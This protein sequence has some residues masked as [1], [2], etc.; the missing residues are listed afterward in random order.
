MLRICLKRAYVSA[1]F[2]I[3]WAICVGAATI[4]PA[5]ALTSPANGVGGQSILEGLSWNTAASATSYEAQVST[6]SVFG[7]TFFDQIGGTGFTSALVANLSPFTTYYWRAQASDSA[8]SSG[9][10]A[11]RSFTTVHYIYDTATG[12]S[13][14]IA[15]PLSANPTLN[16]VPLN[17][18][19]EIGV[20][21]KAGLCVGSA[22]W[23][24]V[25]NQNIVVVGQDPESPTTDGLNAGDSMFFRVWDYSAGKEG[26]ATVTFSS[27]GATYTADG[28]SQIS[29]LTALAI[30]DQPTLSSPANGLG[31]QPTVLTLAWNTAAGAASYAIQVST[32]SVFS[33]TVLSQSG[34]TTLSRAVTG[35]SYQDTY[36]W[37]VNATNTLGTSPWSSVWS[38]S[39]APA[40]PPV[41]TLSAP[42]NGA[43]GLANALTLSWHTVTTATSYGVQVSTGSTFVSTVA[44]LSGLT[45]ASAAVSG[46]GGSTTYYWRAN[47]ANGGSASAWSGAWRFTTAVGAPAAPLLALP[48][49]GATGLTT[50]VTVSWGAVSGATSYSLR[51]ATASTFA[52]TV[53]GQSGLTATAFAPTGLSSNRTYFWEANATNANGTSIWSSVW[54]FSTGVHLVIPLV[55]SW[56]MKSLNIHPTDS[57]TGGVFGAYKG[58]LL[59]SDGRG[60]VYIPTLGI[61]EIGTLTTGRGY[62]IYT[63]STDTIRVT[64]SPVDVAATPISLQTLIWSIIAYLPQVNMPPATALAGIVSQIILASDNAGDVYWPSLGINEIDTMRVGEGYYV[65]TSAAAT[66]TYPTGSAKRAAS[67]KAFLSLSDP[68]HYAKHRITGNKAYFLARHVYFAGSVVSD[69]CE[70]GAFDTQGNLVGAGTAAS[71]L[72]AFAIWGKDQM[73]KDK[74]GCTLA[75]TISFRLWD[76]RREYPLAVTSGGDP[77]YGI[78]KILI[79]TLAVPGRALISSFNLPR[80]YPNPFRGNAHIAFDVP[81]LGGAADQE[82]EIGVYDMKGCLVTSLI[83]GRYAAGSYAVSWNGRRAGG[84]ASGSNIYILRMKAAGFDKQMKLIELK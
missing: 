74:D 19:D 26:H 72:T 66:L 63:D 36:Y 33:S 62:Q 56:N 25:H 1:P 3:A 40:A 76:G 20:F 82:V 79:A 83:K 61:D 24:S 60:N 34:M 58:F 51:V 10:S 42:T 44:S 47:A 17:A 6:S 50:A 35:L 75:E 39:T 11:T 38:F 29:S 55:A 67:G 65:V 5:P 53:A 30:P 8:G 46:L 73:T 15:L 16:G 45:T 78:N 22:V 31:N 2:L 80:V 21:S 27:G 70:I 59:V 12:S 57:T 23:D 69:K 9:W 14:S 7:T 37:M 52:T 48:A 71:G 49:N 4:P 68:R 43:T 84:S 18:Y 77:T 28:Y 64:G 41:P 32:T 13:M 54:S 81:A